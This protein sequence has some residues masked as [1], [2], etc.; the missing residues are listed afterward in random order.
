M[1]LNGIAPRSP[2]LRYVAPKIDV[3]LVQIAAS[4]DSGSFQVRSQRS[5]QSRHGWGLYSGAG[6]PGGVQT[7]TRRISC[8]GISR[9][10]IE[11]GGS[12]QPGHTRSATTRYTKARMGY[13][14][15]QPA[16]HVLLHIAMLYLAIYPI[17]LHAAPRGNAH[18]ALCII[19]SFSC[20][21]VSSVCTLLE[22]L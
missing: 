14:F 5:P 17:V 11:Y 3:F 8:G 9:G 7:R 4:A 18:G 16:F 21:L 1:C 19:Q 12:A 10:E 20:N 2:Q 22:S 13:L 15:T 6:G